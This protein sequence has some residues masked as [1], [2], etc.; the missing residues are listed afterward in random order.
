MMG[1]S[2]DF[3]KKEDKTFNDR[4]KQI[5]KP[6]CKPGKRSLQQSQSL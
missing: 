2:S 6:C 5:Q 1:L 4:H 3:D